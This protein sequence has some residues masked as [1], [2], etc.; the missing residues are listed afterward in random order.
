M[1]SPNLNKL[2]LNI[3][4]SQR[5]LGTTCDFTV[6]PNLSSFSAAK[7][8]MIQSVEI[9]NSFY[10]I[11]SDTTN[12]KIRLVKIRNQNRLPQ[13]VNPP[14]TYLI[15]VNLVAK[16]YNATSLAQALQST[17][18]TWCSS[19]N[20]LVDTTVQPFIFTVDQDAYRF[21]ISLDPSLT[22]EWGFILPYSPLS[23]NILGF[24]GLK[25][26]STFLNINTS[27]NTLF[28][29]VLILIQPITK[30]NLVKSLLM[31]L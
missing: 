13:A 31:L 17:V 21:T 8:V 5:I 4:S 2:V 6:N 16:N 14:T 28:A 19:N 23:T 11:P 30:N 20:V 24:T 27:N 22:A 25:D 10:N 29:I 26:D 12:F 9:V 3:D 18:N 15:N 1:Y 7:S